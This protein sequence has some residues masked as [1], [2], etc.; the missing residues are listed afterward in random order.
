MPF[1]IRDRK[2][3]ARAHI[4]TGADTACRMWSTGGLLGSGYT[5]QAT[6]DGRQICQMCAGV[7]DV[8][9]RLAPIKAQL[10]E[11]EDYA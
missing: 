10:A 3:K 9:H 11:Y 8:D 7:A 5:V 1:L 2:T 6:D 4:W